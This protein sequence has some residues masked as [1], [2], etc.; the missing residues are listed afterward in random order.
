MHVTLPDGTRLELPEGATGHDAA[1]AIGP[2]LAKAAVAVRVGDEIRDLALPLADGDAITIVTPKSGD[3]YLY[4]MRHSAAHVTAEAVGAVIPGARLGFGPPIEDGF[5]YDFELPRPLTEED[6][7]AIE[8][9]IARIRSAKAPFARSVMSIDDARAYFAERDDTY[10][11]DQVEELARQGEETVSLYRQ[12]DFVDLCRG[13]HVQDTGRIGPVKLLSVA[14]AYWR[15]SEKNPQLTRLYATAFT[16][17]ADL[18]AHLERLEQARARDHRRLG[19]DLGLFHFDDYGPGFPFFLPRGMT[20]VN[21]IKAAVR[22]ELETMGYDEI[23]TPTMLSDEL[24]KISGHWDHYRDNMY[25]AEVEDQRFAIKPMN[26][27]GACLVYRSRRHSY[28]ELPLRFAEFGHVHRHELSGVLHGLFRVR[29]FTQDDAH[30]F[31]RLDQVQDEV[32]A[33]LALTDRFYRRFGFERVDLKL[34]TKPEKAVGTPE[35]WE[36]AEE[37]L[38]NA[39]GDRP[40]GIKE[41]DGAFYGP[42]ID[43]EVTDVMG[44]AWQLGTCQLDFNFPERFDLTYTTADDTEERPV[45]IH[46]AIT[47]SL[48]RFLGILI[49][50]TG[51]DFPLWLAP[52]QARVLPVADRHAPYAEAV[53]TRLRER[54]L[55]AEVD[56]RSGSV[57]RRI[58]DGELDKVPFLLVVGDTEADAGTAS[59]RARHGGDRGTMPL[60]ELADWLAAEA[61]SSAAP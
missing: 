17:K 23:Q 45:M 10:K 1:A 42:K 4:V 7:P 56:G 14:G 37:A 61:Q 9:E 59:V 8:A 30:V 50:N 32:R 26:C 39:L 36:A 57:G 5:Y 58:R 49:E 21:G 24:W 19:R 55:R 13:P 6:F 12:R 34:S 20:V 48:E 40:Y 16:S 33:V 51:G 38:R 27:P 28:R 53:R 41:G 22:D 3:D 54:G 2:G 43:F 29:A 15:G 25:F 18:D 47:G 52:E 35:M 44:R 31:C 11:V 46:R 60:G